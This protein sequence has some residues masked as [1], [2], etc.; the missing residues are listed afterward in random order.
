MSDLNFYMK[1]GEV[2]ALWIIIQKAD[3]GVSRYLKWRPDF[4]SAIWVLLLWVC[5]YREDPYTPV[6]SNSPPPK[7]LCWDTVYGI[8]YMLRYTRLAWYW[9]GYW[10]I[11][12]IGVATLSSHLAYSIAFHRISTVLLSLLLLARADAQNDTGEVQTLLQIKAG[13]LGQFWDSH[14]LLGYLE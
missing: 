11:K 4:L 10:K 14:R 2:V 9:E 6:I 5:S 3:L 12:N 8:R 7:N 13:S 1:I